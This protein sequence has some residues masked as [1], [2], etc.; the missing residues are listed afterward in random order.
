MLT[1]GAKL[2]L[3]VGVL[4]VLCVLIGLV[5]FT[6]TS[7]VN[8]KLEELTQV[9]EPVNSA[10]YAIENYLAETA[11]ATLAYSAT[12]DRRLLSA[13]ERDPKMLDSSRKDGTGVVALARLAGLRSDLQDSIVNFHDAAL[14]QVRA[15]DV[16]V[17]DLNALRDELQAID[18]LLSDRVLRSISVNDPIAY[19]RLQVAL[20]MQVQMNALAKNLGNY[21]LTGDGKFTDQLSIAEK[22]FSEFLSVHQVVLLSAEEKRWAAELQQRSADE[23]RLARALIE[24]EKIRRSHL[25]A[26]MESYHSLASTLSKRVQTRTELNLARVKDDLL[27]AGRTRNNTILGVLGVSLIFGILAGIWTTRS[28]T[29]PLAHLMS[30]MEKVGKGDLSQKVHLT[31]R[32]ELHLVGERF[33]A[34]VEQVEKA[35][36]ERNAGLRRFASSMQRAQEAERA[37][38]SRELHDDLCQRLSGMKFRVEVLEEEGAPGDRKM[39]RQLRDVREELDRS[40]AE[41]RRISSNLRPSVLDDFGLATALRLLAKDF[42]KRQDITARVHCTEGIPTDLRGD[43]EI[44]LYRI[45]QEALANIAKHAHATAVEIQLSKQNASLELR[46]HDNGHGIEENDMAGMR[47]EGHGFGML[48]MRERAELLGGSFAVDSGPDRGTTVTVILPVGSED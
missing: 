14:E 18:A 7:A 23:L 33:N 2:G 43:S 39:A 46:I 47:A 29:K 3:G 16:Q 1:I 22:R 21:L 17:R 38:I 24:S 31:G 48:G 37:R 41:V 25:D 26:F 45:C 30:V 8:D 5:S 6:Q 20:G 28:I 34:M 40:I 27:V 32:D 19:R 44:A 12:G 10:V 11:F 15:R 35:E 13:I 4:L 42:E 9:R 36:Q